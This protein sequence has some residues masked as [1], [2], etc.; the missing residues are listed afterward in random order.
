MRD[1]FPDTPIFVRS[2]ELSKTQ[3]LI[4]AGATEVIVATG[5]V[6]SGIGEMLGVKR[7]KRFFAVL[8]ESDA[9]VAFNNMATSLYPPV[10]KENSDE[11]LSGLAEEIDSDSDRE[12]TRKLFKLFSTSLSINED[13]KVKLS[14]LVNELLRT[15]DSIVGDD[16]LAELLGCET[17][18]DQCMVIKQ[19]RYV[20]FSEFVALYRK[21]VTLGKEHDAN[22]R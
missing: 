4:Q 22:A 18:D 21:N 6:A 19:E 8:D 7:S 16:Q 5:S 17:L 20:T 9:A 1:A 2:D 13:G 14:E 10:S 11:K 15:T 3:K 12:E